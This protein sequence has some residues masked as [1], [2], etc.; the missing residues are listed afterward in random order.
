MLDLL[1]KRMKNDAATELREA[2][3]QQRQIT[4]L[5]LHRWLESD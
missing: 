1:E 4:E 2:A 5:R 3:K